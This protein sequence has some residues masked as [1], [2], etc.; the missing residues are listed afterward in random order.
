MCFLVLHL[1]VLDELANPRSYRAYV[2]PS[3]PSSIK[4]DADKVAFSKSIQEWIKP[5]V[6]KHKFLRGGV[7]IIDVVPKSASG[8]ILRRE[9]RELANKEVRARA[10]AKL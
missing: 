4:S 9:L 2:V 10:Q 3:N 5:R 1:A 6:A 8:K 7:V